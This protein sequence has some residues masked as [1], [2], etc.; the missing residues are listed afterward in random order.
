MSRSS[1]ANEFLVYIGAY[2]NQSDIGIS[3]YG[4]DPEDLTISLIEAY[5]GIENASYL[6][7]DSGGRK[8]YA[9][10]ETMIFEGQHGGSVSAYDIEGNTGKLTLLNRQPTYG[11]APCY[12]C[13]DWTGS[14]L[15]AANYHGDNV[16]LIPLHAGGALTSTTKVFIHE[17]SG[18]NHDRQERPHPHSILVDPSNRFAIAA[19]L[20]IDRLVVY[21]I[22]YAAQLLH[23]RSDYQAAPGAGPRHFVFHPKKPYAYLANELVNTISVL[24]CDLDSPVPFTAVQTIT[25]LPDDFQG[26]NTCA[27]IHVSPDGRFLYV[28]NRGHDSLA[29]YAIDLSGDQL[30]FIEHTST[31]G[32][33]PRN[34]GLTPDGS[35][36]FAANQQSDQVVIFERDLQ[37]GQLKDTGQR[38]SVS[39]PVFVQIVHFQKRN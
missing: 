27:D 28:S 38:I 29:V 11:G 34:F 2:T 14:L 39:E 30:T 22:D 20:G 8:L 17:G 16:S 24:A 13:T 35:Y 3:L 12:V 23:R 4:F 25:T 26:D 21:E 7:I 32:Q 15:F 1:A 36:L 18:P 37:S 33:T 19:D 31:L 5:R 10:S 6:S 9:V